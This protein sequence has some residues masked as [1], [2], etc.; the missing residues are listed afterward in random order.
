MELLRSAPHTPP[1]LLEIEG[2]EKVNP[3]R[4]DGRNV[5][6]AGRK[7]SVSKFQRFEVF[8]VIAIGMAFLSLTLTILKLKF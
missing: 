6:E 5:R 2:D 8:K 1:L 3:L 4:E 7:L